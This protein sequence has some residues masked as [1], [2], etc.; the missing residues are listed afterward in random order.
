[1]VNT[2]HDTKPNAVLAL[3]QYAHTRLEPLFAQAKQVYPEL[4]WTI[5]LTFADAASKYSD[6]SHLSVYTLGTTTEF[7]ASTSSY[8]LTDMETIDAYTAQV[9]EA[10]RAVTA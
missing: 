7:Y 10:V 1:M 5:K 2:L 3:A 4:Q 8:V 6:V 9:A